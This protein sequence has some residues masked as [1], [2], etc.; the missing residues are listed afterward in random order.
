MSGEDF[1][2]LCF[3]EK[4][5][6]LKEYFTINSQ[7]EV[8]QRIS[9]LMQNGANR[10]DLF[11]LINLVLRENYYALLLGLDG[12]ASLGGR[13]ISYKVYDE[14]GNFLN[15]CGEIEEAA[16]RYFMEE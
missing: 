1:V 13:K 8:A 16:Y 11:E 15:E 6:I 12:E 9:V 4:E 7:T 5:T 10:D 2:K 3:E 14:D